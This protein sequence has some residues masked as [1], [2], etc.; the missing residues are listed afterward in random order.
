MTGVDPQH[1]TEEIFGPVAAVH[2]YATVDEAVALANGTPY[3]LEAYVLGADAEQA[4]RRR[5]PGPR[6]RGEGQRLHAS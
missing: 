2:A 5:P 3:G 1:T 6:R 4:R